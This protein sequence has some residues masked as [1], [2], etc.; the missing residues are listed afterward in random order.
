MKNKKLLILGLLLTVL[1]SA[2]G[3]KANQETMAT[4]QAEAIITAASG[5]AAAMQ[6]E[7]A[8]QNP[9]ATPSL[10]PMP[11]NTPLPVTNTPLPTIPPA[12]TDAPINTG[13]GS[14]GQCDSAAF[15]AETVPDDTVFAP[16]TVFTKVWEVRN[17]G[18][19]TWTTAYT[20]VHHS[21][22]KMGLA[23]SNVIT[24]ANVPPGANLQISVNMTAPTEP[25]TYYSH[26]VL[27]NAN[28]QTF[29]IGGTT[30][31]SKIIVA[32][33]A[34]TSTP[35]T[36]IAQTPT[37]TPTSFGTV[38]LP[39]TDTPTPVPTQTPVV[40]VV[41]A[42]FTPVPPTNTPVPLPTDTPVPAPTDTPVP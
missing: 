3:G 20:L 7:F 41:T 4:S 28:G 27:K 23:D 22:Q 37:I 26:W 35:G 24:V 42:T 12:A 25:G 13:G 16:G 6:T 21:E 11:S 36:P 15:I 2:C 34:A 1:I 38:V 39:N 17:S 33:D 8:L 10:T 14:T 5:T 29:Q 18:T 9:T 31:W 19:C 30:L 40:I 32:S